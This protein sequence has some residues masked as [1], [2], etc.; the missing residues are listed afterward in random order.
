MMKVNTMIKVLMDSNIDPK[1]LVWKPFGVIPVDSHEEIEILETADIN[2]QVFRE[3][4]DFFEAVIQDITG[5]YDYTKGVTPTRQERVGTMYSIQ[6]VGEARIK[7]LML[8][9]DY[10][11]I[12]PLLKYLTLLNCYHLPSGSEYRISGKNNAEFGRV[13]AD[14]LKMDYDFEA[15]YASM[16][17]A[18][19]KENRIANLLQ[20]S[21]LWQMDPY[22][23]NY[24]FKKAILE[25]ADMPQPDRFL[26]DPRMV[27]Q[28]LAQQ[29]TQALLPDIIREESKQKQIETKGAFDLEKTNR[30][31]AG[32]L[33]K[34]ILTTQEKPEQKPS[35][36]KS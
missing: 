9:M 5:I 36:R 20:L 34:S 33:A 17:P 6:S 12:R 14:A 18:L 23:N 3:Q 25:L 30:K 31:I 26:R 15:K 19:S 32:D 29:Q 13:F 24:E 7:L 21:Q 11:G 4:I 27:A 1:A 16:E 2:S 10:M 35:T 28:M 8:T 22:V